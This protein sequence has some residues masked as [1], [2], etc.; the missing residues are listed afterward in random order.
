MRFDIYKHLEESLAN[1]ECTLNVSYKNNFIRTI[2][3][4]AEL[5]QLQNNDS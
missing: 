4:I 3:I 2:Y 1:C 5:K